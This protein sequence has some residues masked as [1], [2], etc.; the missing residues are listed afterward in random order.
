MRLFLAVLVAVFL[1]A[2]VPTPQAH[3]GGNNPA[4]S[5]D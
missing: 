4:H 3:C 1:A 2:T 5:C